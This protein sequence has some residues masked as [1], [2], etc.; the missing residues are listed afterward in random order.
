MPK[1]SQK[2]KCFQKAWD[3]Y[4]DA[5]GDKMDIESQKPWGLDRTTGQWKDSYNSVWHALNSFW[6]FLRGSSG[7]TEQLRF[8]DLTVSQGGSTSVIDLKFTR[9]NGSVD[10]WGNKEGAGNGATQRDD[11]NSINE[12]LNNGKNPYGNDPSLSAKK[13]KC[14]EPGGTA[15]APVTVLKEVP[16]M[17]GKFFFSPV[18]EALPAPGGV[19]VP[20]GGMVPEPVFP[21]FVF[22]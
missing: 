9:A 18:P 14:D 19:P 17:D 20:G 22:P 6:S 13:C 3:N 10:S 16:S 8:P 1:M 12:Q 2:E 15:T 7:S 5:T 11:Y 21:E 4:K